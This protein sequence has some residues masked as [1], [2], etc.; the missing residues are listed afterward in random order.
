L[1]GGETIDA[2]D[3]QIGEFADLP[4]ELAKATTRNDIP[5]AYQLLDEV[6]FTT[7]MNLTETVAI[8]K[9]WSRWYE[10]EILHPLSG[11]SGLT[12]TQM[13]DIS[14]STAL[15]GFR[16]PSIGQKTMYGG[17]I[18]IGNI[19]NKPVRLR[20]VLDMQ[21]MRIERFK[22]RKIAGVKIGLA[23]PIIAAI[24]SAV[25]AILT[26][27][28]GIIAAVLK[29]KSD[30]TADEQKKIEQATTEWIVDFNHCYP[31]LDGN[32]ICWAMNKATGKMG[33]SKLD[34]NGKVLEN[35]VDP[36]LP[37]NQS[38]SFLLCSQQ[39]AAD[40]KCDSPTGVINYDVPGDMDGDG[41]VDVQADGSIKPSGGGGGMDK[42]KIWDLNIP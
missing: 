5:N 14:K 27:L 23:A 31:T 19:G 30:L 40:G 28:M 37:E 22:N 25:V 16:M 18:A 34:K 41:I 11:V 21:Q 35:D 26:T 6:Y 1:R 38:P 8:H 42:K 12:G 39:D 33:W 7:K 13:D 15:S 4:A 20:T 9:A 10:D 17:K 3:I 36:H 2:N 29:G 32:I 24:I